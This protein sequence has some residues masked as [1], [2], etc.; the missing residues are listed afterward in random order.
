MLSPAELMAEYLCQE[1]ELSWEPS[2]NAT[3]AD[4]R[5]SALLLTLRLRGVDVPSRNEIDAVHWSERHR[6]RKAWS[7]LLA[8]CLSALP[9]AML[10]KN[11]T[12]TISRAAV[13]SCAMRSLPRFRVPAIARKMDCFGNI[14]KFKVKHRKS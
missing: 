5:N 3:C 12:M 13:N 2:Q 9:E 11:T 6:V 4:T 1:L 8:R 7:I 14:D 10:K